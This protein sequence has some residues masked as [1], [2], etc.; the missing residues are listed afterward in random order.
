MGLYERSVTAGTKNATDGGILDDICLVTLALIVSCSTGCL[1]DSS[2]LNASRSTSRNS[3]NAGLARRGGVTAP[4]GDDSG[5]GYE[6]HGTDVLSHCRMLDAGYQ[7]EEAQLDPNKTQDESKRS[8]G[9][10]FSE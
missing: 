3:I 2:G 6:A 4:A 5:E 8:P 10:Q 9:Y 1:G 7:E